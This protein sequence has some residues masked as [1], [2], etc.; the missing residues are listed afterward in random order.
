[1]EVVNHAPSQ[2]KTV[3]RI[4]KTPGS[5]F[6]WIFLAASLMTLGWIYP[7]YRSAIA[8]QQYPGPYTDPLRQFGIVSFVIVLVVAG[9]TLRRRFMRDLPGRVQDW[10]WLHIWFGVISVLIAFMHNNFQGI[11]H[12]FSWLPSRF[13]EAAYGTT[14]LYA[15]LALVLTGIIGRLLDFWL[16]R[17]IAAEADRNGVGI[18]RSVDER[19][20]ALSLSVERLSAGKS[21]LFKQFC[22]QRLFSGR[23]LAFLLR[24]CWEQQKL[25]PL[26]A[27][28]QIQPSAPSRLPQQE[29]RDFER[30]SAV[31]AEYTMLA[32]SLRRQLLAQRIIMVWRYIHIPLAC[33][34]T[35]VIAYHS[36]FELWK[37][38]VLHQ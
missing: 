12:D 5:I 32:S 2:K 19:L 1:M 23:G 17:V 7:V 29:V 30:A 10:L 33:A 26:L 21:D 37:M 18:S 11:T 35:I 28:L 3:R 13:T 24:Y 22:E 31:L 25:S 15:L 36:I 14:A 6:N 9:Y 27:T 20:F 8:T 38:L 16:A 4:W 34:A